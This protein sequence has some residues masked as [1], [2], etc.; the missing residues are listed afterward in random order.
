M[1]PLD[2]LPWQMGVATVLLW[3]LAFT[4]EPLAR[5]HLAAGRLHSVLDDWCPSVVGFYL[6]YPSRR[7]PSRAQMLVVDA[8]RHRN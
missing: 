8:L 5:P 2:V 4:L 6:Y 7:L 1:S 3:I